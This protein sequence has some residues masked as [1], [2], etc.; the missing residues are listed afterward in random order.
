MYIFLST[1]LSI[2]LS[3]ERERLGRQYKYIHN[4]FMV[5]FFPFNLIYIFESFYH[6]YIPYLEK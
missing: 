2:Y 6:E 1:C 3:I 4:G 5:I